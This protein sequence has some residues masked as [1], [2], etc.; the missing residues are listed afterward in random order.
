M[1]ESQAL[2]QEGVPDVSPESPGRGSENPGRRVVTEMGAPEENLSG[3]DANDRERTARR[4]VAA[5]GSAPVAV[6]V[7]TRVVCGDARTA[8][9]VAREAVA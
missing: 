8:W 9:R 6:A 4:V 3:V 1:K 2:G 5:R 7:V